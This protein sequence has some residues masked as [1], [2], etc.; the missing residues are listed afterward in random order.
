MTSS[1]K[2]RI[3]EL[4]KELNLDNKEVIDAATK[5]SISVKSHS[6]S[7]SEDD[8]RKIKAILKKNKSHETIKNPSSKKILSVQKNTPEILSKT[9]P[10]NR[11]TNKEN[12]L[13]V[14]PALKKEP[15]IKND[16][17]PN[18]PK[19]SL[20]RNTQLKKPLDLKKVDSKNV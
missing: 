1:G 4:S 5:L 16:S 20:L 12:I 7:I 3:Y 18:R 14:K 2:I 10:N 8:S 6:S 11:K 15:S 17:L 9:S 19:D 13:S